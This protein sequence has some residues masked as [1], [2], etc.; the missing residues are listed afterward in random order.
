MKA[1]KRRASN[2]A[3]ITM[4]LYVIYEVFRDTLW[5]SNKFRTDELHVYSIHMVGVH[6]SQKNFECNNSVRK[7]E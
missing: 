1:V 7:R 2:I 3:R 6:P 4:D 5:Y